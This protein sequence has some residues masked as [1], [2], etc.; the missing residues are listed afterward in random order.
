MLTQDDLLYKGMRIPC[1]RHEPARP[2]GTVIYLPGF[3]TQGPMYEKHLQAFQQYRILL[4]ELY[5]GSHPISSIDAGINLAMTF[6]RHKSKEIDL[7]DHILAGYSLGGNI[8]AHLAADAGAD[9]PAPRGLILLSPA[10]SGLDRSMRGY[11]QRF[12]KMG[13][14]LRFGE[15]GD[16][17]RAFARKQ[18]AAFVGRTLMNYYRNQQLIASL[19]TASIPDG[20]IS[21]PTLAILSE[22]DEF[23]PIDQSTAWITHA[24]PK[25]NVERIAGSHA[26]I[27]H[28]PD[29]ANAIITRYQRLRRKRGS[30]TQ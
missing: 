3:E 22:Q 12:L 8:A 17:G 14:R 16:A 1:W 27:L 5:E 28:T 29:D 15:E 4:L 19:N 20:A 7:S 10:I 23:F 13:F 11:E 2:A 30:R 9:H 18:G 24:C 25:V 26:R 6:Y 21:I